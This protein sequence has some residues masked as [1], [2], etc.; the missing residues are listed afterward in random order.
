MSA[1]FD[2][3]IPAELKAAVAGGWELD[4]GVLFL[5]DELLRC[6][7]GLDP[8]TARAL[9]FLVT[10]ILVNQRRGS[11]RLPL[12]DGTLQRIL[13]DL[14]ATPADREAL[15]RVL[16]GARAD[17]DRPLAIIGAVGERKPL[18]LDGG[19]LY[20]QRMW[21]HEE[22]LGDALRSRM[23]LD[24]EAP[25]PALLS[26]TM[27]AMLERVPA[28]GG[29]PIRLSDEQREAVLG[30]L[31]LPLA[32]ISGGPGTGKTSI[33]VSILRMLV[34]LGTP[35]ERIALAAPTGK[36]AHRMS[37]SILGYLGAIAEPEAADRSLAASCPEPRTLHRL[38][39]WS[40]R[41]DG[42]LH[43]ERNPLPESVVIVDEASMIDLQL[44]ERLLRSLRPDARLVLLG[45][46]EQ[47]PS[48]DAGAVLRDLL[49]PP[50]TKD[51]RSRF[52]S[53]LTQSFRMDPSDPAGRNIL[54]VARAIND[55]AAAGLFEGDEPIRIRH[56]AETVEFQ[57]VELLEPGNTGSGG[58]SLEGFL[59]R[60]DRARIRGLPGFA[61]LSKREY[62]HADG[63]FLPEDEA[64]LSRLFRHF[65]E[66][67]IL[68]VTRG[69]SMSSGA[70]AVNL[71]L[72][73]KALARLGGGH[74]EGSFLP[75]EPVILQR[76]DYARGL[77]N[78]DQG[79]V[80][81]VRDVNDASHRFQAV[82]RRAGSFA[83]FGLDGLRAH[84]RHAYAM[85]VHK[86]QGSEFDRI[87]LI[88]PEAPMPLLTRE[89][90]Y[91]A[92]TR[93]RKGAVIVGARAV[94]E[95]GVVNR[96]ERHSGIAA[97][98]ARVR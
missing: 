74:R 83:I 75:G 11:T 92:L 1:R 9:Y 33:V 23:A 15:E 76:N 87:A 49:P 3:R 30:A 4:E 61:E 53:R 89:L 81:R 28:R 52:S 13:D 38:L 16:G 86:A 36:A 46:A 94:L 63:A 41:A 2:D 43:H 21:R 44:M 72:H 24:V 77:F 10:A 12:S 79:L 29:A 71:A 96:L 22:S 6:E 64:A 17:G 67:R 62:V 20:V 91:T 84:L 8:Q 95:S 47:L 32:V 7:P 88:L 97:R 35:L 82:F 98:I 78:G 66:Q 40:P 93:S 5:A 68:C 58:A 51:A 27:D 55:G 42:F 54:T 31:R 85:T 90:V 57:G 48:V 70:E 56:D 65:E 80:V 59:E 39:G 45:D 69:D 50:G 34:R 14:G 26:R 37:E 18:L 73:R 25:D 60:W 19:N